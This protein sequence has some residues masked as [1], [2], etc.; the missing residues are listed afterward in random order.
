MHDQDVRLE[1]LY[2]L[3]SWLLERLGPA[4][5][6]LNAAVRRADP[7]DDRRQPGSRVQQLALLLQEVDSALD[8]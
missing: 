6:V 2:A 4:T 8:G 3:R 5:E 1:E 7:G